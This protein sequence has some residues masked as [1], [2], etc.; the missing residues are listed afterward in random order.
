[1]GSDRWP[2]LRQRNSGLAGR[3]ENLNL[4]HFFF[5][6]RSDRP[7][8]SEERSELSALTS[9]AAAVYCT[10]V[11]IINTSYQK[12]PFDSGDDP[13]TLFFHQALN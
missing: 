5:S 10:A 7:K 12:L 4:V 1:M 6:A 8:S 9:T 13:D 3:S 2:R 11:P